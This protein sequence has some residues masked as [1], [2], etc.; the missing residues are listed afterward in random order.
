MSVLYEEPAD[1]SQYL[2]LQAEGQMIWIDYESWFDPYQIYSED[3]IEQLP[4]ELREFILK[5]RKNAQKAKETF[6]PVCPE[7]HAG[8]QFTYQDIFYEIPGM[9]E[10]SNELY[11]SLS[12]D[13][14]RELKQMGCRY[15]AY[16]GSID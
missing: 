13:M 3:S 15:V 1:K 14:E 6:V 10:I 16:T 12:P 7:K 5:W 4:P 11:A 8:T 9:P 2:S